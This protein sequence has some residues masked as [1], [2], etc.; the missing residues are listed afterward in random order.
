MNTGSFWHRAARGK[1][2]R[3]GPVGGDIS[4]WGVWLNDQLLC[5]TYGSAEEAAYCASRR[6]FGD[7]NAIRRWAG[8]SVPSEISFWRRIP[9]EEP[10]SPSDENDKS[11][12]KNRPWKRSSTRI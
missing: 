8:I 1:V 9:P 2:V 10:V 12:C 6:D 4:R 11:E 3:I 7:E 5:D